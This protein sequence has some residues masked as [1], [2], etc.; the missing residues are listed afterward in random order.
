M[1]KEKKK[2]NHV[3]RTLA[4]I[5]IASFCLLIL[6]F[7]MSHPRKREIPVLE[8]GGSIFMSYDGPVFPLTSSEA[9]PGIEV[10]R[11]IEF[12]LSD[13]DVSYG[14]R[15]LR[16][17]KIHDRYVLMN[18][19]TED[20]TFTALYPYVSSF[21]S[22]L[23][24][25]ITVNGNEAE[26]RLHSGMY[27]G[28]FSGAGSNTESLNLNEI[29]SWEGYQALLADDAYIEAAFSDYPTLDEPVYVY[30][31]SEISD[32]GSDAAAPTLSIEFS[33]DYNQ[34]A[35]FTYGFNGGRFEPENNYS[36]RSFFIPAKDDYDYGMLRMLI[37][38]GDDIAAYDIQGYQNGGCKPGEEIEGAEA[39]IRR[40]ETTLGDILK[41][42]TTAHYEQ[43][44]RTTAVDE[45]APLIAGGIS[46]EM[47]YGELCRVFKQ[48][49]IIGN[50]TKER[51]QTG[52]VEDL[53]SDVEFYKRILYEAFEI[54]I[55]AG[56]SISVEVEFKKSGS[57]D[58]GGTGGRNFGVTGYDFV[59]QLGSVLSFKEQSLVLSNDNGIE[60]VRQNV[61]ID[62]VQNHAELD[63]NVE[64]YY[65]EVR[66]TDK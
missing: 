66:S 51:Y 43:S 29:S 53:L 64:H 42:I 31:F 60:I 10:V 40:Y 23:N 2:N 20:K 7:G 52:M 25:I 61:G 63:L 44:I 30:E 14:Y 39:V 27:S 49:S 55:P 4:I 17:S 11:E 12:D 34:T 3:N 26:T 8:D 65:L 21:D 19:T 36:Q 47:I 16:Q 58:F 41:T 9:V 50:D 37:V 13:Y 22:K 54:T 1:S 35:V 45:V 28:D 6:A 46:E 56:E 32:G 38:M 18:T 48:Y 33:M 62:P 15:G 5:I 59:T 24:P 57:F